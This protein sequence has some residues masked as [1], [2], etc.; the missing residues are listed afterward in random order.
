MRIV[1]FDEVKPNPG[2]FE[3]YLIGGISFS[4]SSLR[5]TLTAFNALKEK[6]F[7]VLD[8]PRNTEIH[9][10][11]IYHGKGSFKKKNLEFR[12]GLLA[13]LVKLLEPE[14]VRLVYSWIK[15]P[16]LF[17]ASHALDQAF[18]HF[19]ERAHNTLH[20]SE[21]GLLIGD[22][23][24]SSRNH[25]W[26]K[27]GEFRRNGTP[28]AYGQSLPKFADTVHFVDSRAC[29]MVQLADVYTFV[30]SGNAGTRKGYPA[31]RLAELIE[32]VN[33]FPS[34]YKVYPK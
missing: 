31:D 15:I 1:Y 24:S 16:K 10:Q 25:L 18:T 7:G 23:D 2:A 11:Y 3:D 27:F 34:S 28:W 8:V 9:A 22:L 29:E 6:Y 12:L 17:N 13:D 32:G 26:A 20:G 19:C 5:S 30:L 14:D 4:E 21:I 33:L